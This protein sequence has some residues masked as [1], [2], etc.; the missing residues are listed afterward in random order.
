VVASAA[1][2]SAILNLSS[3]A[4]RPAKK[5]ATIAVTAN[6]DKIENLYFVTVYLGG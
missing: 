6:S 1:R 5:A 3:G 4:N 2:C